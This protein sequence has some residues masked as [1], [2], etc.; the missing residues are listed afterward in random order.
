MRIRLL[1][2]AVGVAMGAFGLLRFLQHDLADIVDAVLWLAVGVV[3]HDAV[4]AP[5]TLGVTVVGTR[6]LPRRARVLTTTG[7]I[8]LLTVTATAVPVLG[9]WGAR[10]DNP[11]LLDRNYV[12]GWCVFAVLVLLGSLL[13]LT[14]AWRRLVYRGPGKLQE[15]QRGE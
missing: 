3:V 12:A 5:L 10:P 7:L 8:V 9:S 15:E 13:T 14:P 11:T 4:I 2:G 1:L 6:L